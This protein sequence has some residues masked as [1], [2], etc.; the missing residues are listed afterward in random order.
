M[1]H[2]NHFKLIVIRVKY[3][4]II[5]QLLVTVAVEETSG[6]PRC[7]IARFIQHRYGLRGVTSR[8]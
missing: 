8:V 7:W 6:T 2:F 4:H 3:I 5:V 1:Y